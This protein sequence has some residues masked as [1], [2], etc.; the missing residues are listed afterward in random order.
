MKKFKKKVSFI[1][2][3]TVKDTVIITDYNTGL[4]SAFEFRKADFSLDDSQKEQYDWKFSTVDASRDEYE[5]KKK[6]IYYCIFMIGYNTK[7]EAKIGHINLVKHIKKYGMGFAESDD[8][9]MV[10]SIAKGGAYEKV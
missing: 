1:P 8:E 5:N 10:R 4:C 7:R 3:K 9:E 6:K 2:Q